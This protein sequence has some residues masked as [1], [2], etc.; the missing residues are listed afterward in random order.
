[1]TTLVTEGRRRMH[2]HS[3]EDVAAVVRAAIIELRNR[4]GW[5]AQ[6]PLTAWDELPAGSRTARIERIRLIRGGVLPRD[7]YEAS[8]RP[9]DPPYDAL[10]AKRRDEDQ[11]EWFVTQALTGD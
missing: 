8:A 2:R 10:P 4:Q 9:G 3:D 6:Y 7:Q 11:V 1:V 5:P